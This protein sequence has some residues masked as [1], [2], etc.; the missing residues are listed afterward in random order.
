MYEK[1]IKYLLEELT[2]EEKIGMIHG[3]GLFRNEGVKRLNIPPFKFADG[4][5]GVRNEF[6]NDEWKEIGYTDDFVTY[7]PSGSAIASTWNQELAYQYGQVLGS[8]TRG[9]GKDM[10]LAPSINIVRSPLCGRN[11]EYLSEDPY[12]TQKMAVPMVKGIQEFDVSACCKHFAAN[13]QETERLKVDVLVSEKA[14]NDIYLKAFKAVV[15]E[16]NTLGIMGA[17][18]KLNGEFCS[19]S[20]TLLDDVLRDKWGYEHIVVS[21]W[22]AVNDTMQ[23]AHSSIDIE[24]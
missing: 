7:L 3:N 17:Y 4:P 1:Q 10:I 2:L 24:M 11:F 20:K 21:D 12:L 9:R 19:Q 14:L 16:G 18:N 22:S 5:M 15:E 6:H 13:N 23:A 8:E